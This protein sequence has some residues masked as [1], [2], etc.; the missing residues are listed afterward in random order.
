MF[1]TKIY[2]S[3]PRYN[4]IL[5]LESILSLTIS[6]PSPFDWYAQRRKSDLTLPPG[7]IPLSDYKS[8]RQ[9]VAS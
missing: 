9:C 4:I 2:P 3:V 8:Q 7:S 6:F 1:E 5:L